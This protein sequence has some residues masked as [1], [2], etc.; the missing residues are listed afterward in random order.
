MSCGAPVAASNNS[1]IPEILG[2]LEATFDPADD[3]DIADCLR[4]VLD[5]P[6]ELECLRER[7]R[8][9]V[10]LYTW[11][12]VAERTLE[13]YERA[14][15]APARP[16]PTRTRKRLAMVTPWPPQWTGVATHSRQSSRS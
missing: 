7:S 11:D 1:S 4:R 3:A 2:D 12:R 16:R 14:L 5:S 8:R 6:D 9:R 15:A 10:A 13:G